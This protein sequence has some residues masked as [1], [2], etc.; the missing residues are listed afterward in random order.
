VQQVASH[1]KPRVIGSEFL[2]ANNEIKDSTERFHD[3]GG[4]SVRL[5]SGKGPSTQPTFEAFKMRLGHSR[6]RLIDET[7]ICKKLKSH[8][9]NRFVWSIYVTG[10]SIRPLSAKS[11]NLIAP[12][13]SF[14]AF[15]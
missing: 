6:D 1:Q 4:L 12:T 13:G 11:W 8:F 2:I 14:G 7:S 9:S 10:I 15:T 5:K 3:G